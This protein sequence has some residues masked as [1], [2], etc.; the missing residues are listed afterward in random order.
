MTWKL[1]TS[2][3]RQLSARSLALMLVASALM[4]APERSANMVVS[5]YAVPENFPPPH[6]TQMKS[7]LEGDE[8]ELQSGS[9]QVLIRRVKWQLFNENGTNQL[10]VRAPQCFYDY[11]QKTVYSDGH[12]E[13]QSGDGRFFFEG[14]GFLLHMTNQTLTLSN[15]VHTIINNARP[16]APKP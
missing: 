13:A 6:E 3:S 1:F 5:N 11:T 14:E 4:A 10:I 2:N 7:L 12:L 8:A 9:H 16:A 15:R